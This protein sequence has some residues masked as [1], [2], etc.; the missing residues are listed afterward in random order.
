MSETELK[1]A[2]DNAFPQV[3]IHAGPGKAPVLPV[4]VMVSSQS[5]FILAR[6]ISSE[7]TGDLMAGMWEALMSLGTV[8]RRLIWD[9]ETGSGRRNSYVAG[10]A[11]V[12]GALGTRIVLVKPQWREQTCGGAH[13]PVSASGCR[14]AMPVWSGGPVTAPRTCSLALSQGFW[15]TGL[16]ITGPERLEAAREGLPNTSSGWRTKRAG[17]CGLRPCVADCLRLPSR[18]PDIPS[19]KKTIGE[20]G[21]YSGAM[22]HAGS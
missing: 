15:S 4:L 5:R 18:S 6:I 7:M 3:R 1:E 13:Q 20:I 14:S 16:T 19:A 22:K 2:I 17:P 11:S 8:P 9:N 21:Y 10:V 12:V